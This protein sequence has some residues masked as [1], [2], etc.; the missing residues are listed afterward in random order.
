MIYQNEHLKEISFPIGG[1]GTGCFG[2]AG[3]GSFIDWE[4][5]NR[6]GKGKYLGYTHLAV[7][8]RLEGKTVTK[9]LNGD[10]TKD[11]SGTYDRGIYHG[12]GYGPASQTMA[13]LPH[14]REVEFKGEF[15]IAELTFSDPDF[16][17]KVVLT[18]FNPLIPLDAD[19]SSLP[20]GFFTVK[21]CN[22]TG[23]SVDY[24]V[25]FSLCGNF[26][27]SVNTLHAG[28]GI[29][30]I[31][32]GT[33]LPEDDLHYGD[34]CIATDCPAVSHQQYWYRGAWS[35]NLDVFIKEL[36]TGEPLKNRVYDEPGNG[37]HASL[38]AAGDEVRFILTWNIP[39]QCNDWSSGEFR[40]WKNYY[41]TVFPSALDTAKYCLNN[42][43]SLYT[44]TRAFKNALFGSTLDEA[45]LDAV[46]STLSV[47]KS[48][49]VLRLEDGSFYGWE[50]VHELSGSC[51]GTCQHVWNYAYALCFLFPDLE[52]TNREHEL[53]DSMSPNG[54]TSFRMSLPL[55][56]APPDMRACLDGQMGVVF[57]TY[58][59]W[60]LSG[61]TQWLRGLWERVKKAIA[62]AWSEENPDA[63]DRDRDGILEGRQHHTLDMELFGPSSW[64][65]SMYLCALKAGAEMA[66]FLG[67]DIAGEYLTLYEN[68]K[69]FL[70]EHLFN[71]QYFIQKVDLAD[72]RPI[73]RFGCSNYWYEEAGQLKYQ[74]G[75]GC[76]IDQALGQ[77]HSNLLGLGE[78]FDKAQLTTALHSL[79]KNNFVS[80][81][82]HRNTWRVFALNDE[83]GAIMCSFPKTSPV[84]PVPYHA[85][86][87][88]GFEYALAG[89]MIR[90][91][92]EN[93]GL[94][95]VKAIRDRYDGKKRNPWNE[96][97]CGSNYARA[98]ASFALLPIYSGM[99]FDLPRKMLGF[100]PIHRENFRC[101]FSVGTGW[102]IFAWGKNELRLTLEEGSLTLTQ[103]AVPVEAKAVYADGKELAFFCE[104]SV[105][106]FDET[107][108]EQELTIK[109]G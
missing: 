65:Q 99:R 40:H 5:F 77:W 91:G 104:N 38:L 10:L 16:P 29:T 45:V 32:L 68:G 21:F 66:E 62:Y 106:T 64:L 49:T 71:G 23:M 103:F 93:E 43:D 20:A 1:I 69:T 75:E 17:G 35:D 100:D 101:L 30:A 60:K 107:Y 15:P 11:F 19:N 59:E 73:D 86:V 39:N 92:L 2:I 53:I 42:F 96:I 85:E 31:R 4:I 13:G 33:A 26:P 72:H 74:I 58:R 22:D 12:F 6:P 63:W 14:F 27:Q 34:L 89:L 52:R 90:E 41:A 95:I 54:K 82:Q 51:E 79:W 36:W 56:S 105:I 44:R 47:L 57:K 88:T 67:D 7:Q 25:A 28:D 76:E 18:A 97:E 8:A 46:S 109:I 102:G 37:D 78:I 50:G 84:I 94:A 80:M 9:I 83:A 108:I 98:M 55:G 61:D 24:A 87:M 3:N 48:P 70:K 81:R